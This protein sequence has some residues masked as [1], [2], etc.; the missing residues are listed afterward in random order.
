MIP[1]KRRIALEHR[2]R[3]GTRHGSVGDLH[4][5]DTGIV[6][7]ARNVRPRLLLGFNR[8]TKMFSRLTVY[9][10]YQVGIGLGQAR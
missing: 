3:R 10:H 2:R 8:F 7:N 5:L 6:V 9:R 1:V 4:A